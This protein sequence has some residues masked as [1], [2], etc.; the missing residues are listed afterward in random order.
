MSLECHVKMLG[1]RG[2]RF[3]ALL[4][5]VCADGQIRDDQNVDKQTV[6]LISVI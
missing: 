4:A 5:E 6:G 2:S 1:F 3:S